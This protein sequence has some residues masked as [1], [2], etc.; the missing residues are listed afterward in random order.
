MGAGQVEIEVKFLIEDLD[1]LRSRLIAVGARSIGSVFESNRRYDDPAGRL[2]TARCLLRL[3]Q[4][5]QTHLTFKRPRPMKAAECKVYDEYEVVVED[6]EGMDLILKA[7]GFRC[8]Q[9]YEKYRETFVW[10]KAVICTDRLPYGNFIEIEGAPKTIRK[11]AR[12]LQLP[13]S[14]RI[15]TN[16]LHI[17]EVLR[18]ELGLA[19]RDLTFKVMP[20]VPPKAQDIIRRFEVSAAA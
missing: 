13:W 10:D 12:Q 14:R 4:D 8:V 2:Q 11:T 6:C 9:I 19:Y 3:R 7:I 18:R 15:L 17:F 16:Y 1:A 5:R 20:T